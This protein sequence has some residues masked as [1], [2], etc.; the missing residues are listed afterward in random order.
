MLEL[1]L[2]VVIVELVGF[3]PEITIVT[4]FDNSL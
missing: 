2:D 1:V 4:D 3:K